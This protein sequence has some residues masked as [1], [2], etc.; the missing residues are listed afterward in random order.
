MAFTYLAGVSSLV[1]DEAACTGCGHCLEVCPHDVLARAGPK[2]AV[3]D[4]DQCMECG[5]CARNCAAGA[6]RVRAG[7]GCAQAVLNA[8]LGRS[9]GECCCVVEPPGAAK[10][11]T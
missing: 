6:I 4:R 1:L 11:P 5:A 7:V 9:G 3:R 2:V 10:P 8:S